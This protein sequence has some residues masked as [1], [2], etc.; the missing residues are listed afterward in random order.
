MALSSFYDIKVR[1][2]DLDQVAAKIR[3]TISGLT[4]QIKIDIES[5][6]AQR[7]KGLSTSLEALDKSLRDISV[8]GASAAHSMEKF[9]NAVN[10][11]KGSASQV[12]KLGGSLEKTTKNAAGLTQQ[13][14]NVAK[15]ANSISPAKFE[16]LSSSVSKTTKQLQAGHSAMFEFGRQAGL[17]GRRFIAFTVA[18]GS[19]IGTVGAITQGINEAIKFEDEMRKLSQVTN[20]SAA[21]I[22]DIEGEVRRL[23][24]TLGVSSSELAK[25]SVTLAQAGFSARDT[26]IALE[27]L[28]K[29]DL[30]PTFKNLQSTT[31]GLIAVKAQFKLGAKDFETALSTINKVSAD[32]AIESED[33]IV[34]IQKL[35][36]TFVSAG[37]KIDG[38]G[39][40]RLQEL[41]AVMTSVRATTRESAD[42][43]ATGL[44]TI[45]TRLQTQE[46]IQ[47]LRKLNIELEETDS[48]G[49]RL[50]VGSFE[51]LKR[52]SKGL[53][54]VDS[55]SGTFNEVVKLTA[56]TR[57]SAK[58]IPAIKEFATTEKA[59]QTG[60]NAKDALT[61]DQIIAQK[62]LINQLNKLKETFLDTVAVINKPGPLRTLTEF[63]I[64]AATA[65]TKLTKAFAPLLPLLVARAGFNLFKGAPDFLKGFSSE[66][67]KK[68]QDQN[69]QKTAQIS[70]KVINAQSINT[71]ATHANT[72]ALQANTQAKAQASSG[73]A[74]GSVV[75][76]LA[77]GSVIIPGVGGGGTTDEQI[78][79]AVN[80]ALR[81]R[82]R[83]RRKDINRLKQG[84]VSAA[85]KGLSQVGAG[86]G[87]VFLSEQEIFQNRVAQHDNRKQAE[88]ARL[89]RRTRLFNQGRTDTQEERDA[90]AQ[91]LRLERR[92]KNFGGF[93]TTNVTPPIP[94]NKDFGKLKGSSLSPLQRLF[95]QA[96]QS[97]L[98]RAKNLAFPSTESGRILSSR[99]ADVQSR[100]Q[101]DPFSRA[102]GTGNL[103]QRQLAKLQATAKGQAFLQT[104][105]EQESRVSAITQ[106][107]LEKAQQK[108]GAI[109]GGVA[110]G[111][112]FLGAGLISATSESKSGFAKVGI[113]GIGGGA[114]SGGATGFALGGPVGAAF[115]AVGGAVLGAVSAF[116][117]LKEV[118]LQD[119]LKESFDRLNESLEKVDKGVITFGEAL[120][121]TKD[122]P[123]SD[124]IS[125]QQELGLSGAIGKLFTTPLLSKQ[126]SSQKEGQNF[127]NRKGFIEALGVGFKG[128]IN[129][130]SD[131]E[132]DAFRLNNRE[133]AL[134]IFGQAQAERESAIPRLE[135]SIRKELESG[136]DFNLSND[137][138]KAGAARGLGITTKDQAEL[139]RGKEGIVLSN[140]LLALFKKEVE[141]RKEMIKATYEAEK[142]FD[143]MGK[144]VDTFAYNMEIFGGLLKR[145]SDA[146]EQFAT[147]AERLLGA[148]GGNFQVS[149]IGSPFS[150][151]AANS[152]GFSSKEIL[153]K[154]DSLN[155]L[156]KLPSELR[157]FIQTSTAL[158]DILPRATE[159]AQSKF[160]KANPGENG[161]I[162]VIKDFITE[163]LNALP[164][165]T[166]KN[167][168]QSKLEK[169]SGEG[170]KNSNLQDVVDKFTKLSNESGKIGFKTFED[171]SKLTEDGINKFISAIN[172][173]VELQLEVNKK[174]DRVGE[175]GASINLERATRFGAE[176]DL[177]TILR[178]GNVRINRITGGDS[179]ERVGERLR[180]N[181]AAQEAK[182][183]EV[184]G[185]TGKIGG[186]VQERQ[187]LQSALE[188]F[189]E[190]GLIGPRAQ[191]QKELRRNEGDTKT[192]A[193]SLTKAPEELKKLATE[194]SELTSVLELFA[195]GTKDAAAIQDK[196]NK[197]NDKRRAGGDLISKLV[198]GGGRDEI[199]QTNAVA[200]F[201][202]GDNSVLFR[203]GKDLTEGVKLFADL[204]RKNGLEPQAENLEATFNKRSAEFAGVDGRGPFKLSG[205][206][207]GESLEERGLSALLNEAQDRQKKAAEILE[208]VAV[209]LKD[210]FLTNANN[211][212][213]ALKDA[214]NSLPKILEERLGLGKVGE[215]KALGGPIRGGSGT[216]D[217]IPIM[218]MG[219]E[220][221]VKRSQAKK[222]RKLLEDINN[223]RMNFAKG[224][225]VSRSAYDIFK[226]K[227]E[228]K[229][230]EEKKKFADKYRT[231][232]PALVK[233]IDEAVAVKRAE[234]R[235]RATGTRLTPRGF[236]A[237]G[238]VREYIE[239][240]KNVARLAASEGRKENAKLL[241]DSYLG[242]RGD[243]ADERT[244]IA[245]ARTLKSK[246]LEDVPYK[247]E[248]D[249]LN[250]ETLAKKVA[251]R[252]SAIPVPT[253]KRRNAPGTVVQINGLSR[254][255]KIA[256]VNARGKALREARK[257]TE[258][259][260]YLG[261]GRRETLL[262]SD[263]VFDAGRREFEKTQKE[264]RINAARAKLD[265]YR[266]S[267]DYITGAKQEGA[268]IAAQQKFAASPRG[269]QRAANKAAYEARRA[270]AKG[271]R[272]P[273]VG[274]PI[275][276]VVPVKPPI[277]GP[278]VRGGDSGEDRPRD[279][280]RGD[281]GEDRPRDGAPIISAAKPPIAPPIVPFGRVAVIRAREEKLKKEALL[282][283][284]AR[285]EAFVPGVKPTVVSSIGKADPTI[286][287]IIDKNRAGRDKPPLG[288]DEIKAARAE[289]NVPRIV[290]AFKEEPKESILDKKVDFLK[291]ELGI[292]RR[293]AGEFRA[294]GAS[295]RQEQ[296]ARDAAALERNNRALTEEEFKKKYPFLSGKRLKG[297][298]QGGLV[299]NTIGALQTGEYIINK[300]SA[301]NNYGLLSSIN[302]K[303]YAEGGVVGDIPVRGADV[304]RYKRADGTINPGGIDS[305]KLS[306]ALNNFSKVAQNLAKSLD[307]L[308]NLNIPERIEI[309]GNINTTLNLTGGAGIAAELRQAIIGVAQTIIQNFVREETRKQF[310]Y[311]T[312]ESRFG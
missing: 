175:I 68:A 127:I 1:V 163:T 27:A 22:K 213:I 183:A 196:L 269:L 266:N 176:P 102:T 209:G 25:S 35:G 122:K 41:A 162:Q 50:F 100:L 177:D 167:Q 117:E 147:K 96:R 228:D 18:A 227:K 267:F 62:T 238:P 295:V 92:G 105:L 43:I 210:D 91:E 156:T 83:N 111:A 77:D 4:G 145:T 146:Q 21:G 140:I 9:Q 36:G 215:G 240:P 272:A 312:G 245:K 47:G 256:E 14:H 260:L 231:A 66:I 19:I 154:F 226:K 120:T 184:G 121:T 85:T 293:N 194:A 88:F 6:S 61:D 94:G 137:E 289:R 42:T 56:G 119:K 225:F 126:S 247:K 198:A 128:L 233:R 205:T 230:E 190:K 246:G 130:S 189:S 59:L 74:R 237:E 251:R 305:G 248:V 109:R 17:A 10:G 288:V 277:V 95:A 8:S 223:G 232:D 273:A 86:T 108:A 54:E 204:L 303:G 211:A 80:P 34:G 55:R 270:A 93:L 153:Q 179:V 180:A 161:Q 217:D 275:V 307:S 114:L 174:L 282:R 160:D 40:D 200:Q 143:E 308:K 103:S 52:L 72:Q 259:G 244:A 310:N 284:E 89:Q 133:Q 235:F 280:L 276:P 125:S 304:A 134:E 214:A 81:D 239:D 185:L 298:A 63:A 123:V 31:E 118:L 170:L 64:S 264:K 49:Q 5:T 219:G 173:G 291:T 290:Q 195:S 107:N 69:L 53:A 164:S 132:K 278:I 116:E 110:I 141:S 186:K 229:I 306:E 32:F 253:Q 142:A 311:L 191:I 168:F 236:G 255:E 197:A 271:I 218:A 257:V 71:T 285:K 30:S 155:A 97:A 58:V 207:R 181:L 73:A 104:K 151:V 157:D 115:G 29:T 202:G 252:G 250:G 3:S 150:S 309:T 172:K 254:E 263:P 87:T 51:A 138:L 187:A 23:A 287:A 76:G 139:V 279:R 2:K 212:M 206:A 65:V 274:L 39:I 283:S 158:R 11:I 112:G 12:D 98:N 165:N 44:R 299:D 182:N 201:L 261:T 48:K 24:T 13:T 294:R 144:V 135:K 234:D 152:E 106:R 113:G 148:F 297:Y 79:S 192:L 129:P 99:V 301:K 28:A 292:S 84:R 243:I 20:K 131:I 171:A 57:Q 159:E 249:I 149:G 193:D 220:F 300:N 208:K 16:A 15:A 286:K 101:S 203:A 188:K 265:E 216:R 262:D 26:K 296:A 82:L 242:R 178:E 169:L 124:L 221:I 75:Q 136:R 268:R 302:R 67:Q 7:L 78:N 90:F 60:K 38:D 70:A 33:I 199:R 224:D 222:H 241:T 46:V 166:I 281:S 45:F 37:K 258:P